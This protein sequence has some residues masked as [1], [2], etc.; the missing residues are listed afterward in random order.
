MLSK[1]RI[2]LYVLMSAVIVI[3]IVL[4]V[5]ST[6]NVV[7]EE[8]MRVLTLW[9]IDGFEGGKGSRA[10]YLQDKAEQCFD[11]LPIY[12]RVV[13]VS[14]DAAR[15]NIKEGVKPDIISYPAGFYGLE[16]CIPE[17]YNEYTWCRGGYC[18]IALGE[19]AQ[20]SDADEKNTVINC[21]KDN[22]VDVA[23]L[24]EGLYGADAESPTSAYLKLINGKYKYLLGTQR[25]IYRLTTRGE[26]FS[27]KALSSF[28]DL[29][30]NICALCGGEDEK[31]ARQF[32]E[33]LLDQ[34]DADKLGM[35]TPKVNYGGAMKLL[36][37]TDAEYKLTTLASENYIV[38]LKNAASGGD[39]N[40]VKSL[41]K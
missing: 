23:A 10:Q 9:Q 22:L 24:L 28:N 20:F 13:S 2:V 19:N 8:K 34:D 17:N 40:L 41:I 6:E 30:Q 33:F 21:G 31:Y 1:K 36:A 4:S 32:I 11:G 39:I 27:V 37:D 25:D 26:V 5:C 3:A 18:F 35:I 7:R 15:K 38:K 12:F 16:S 14:A 29:Y